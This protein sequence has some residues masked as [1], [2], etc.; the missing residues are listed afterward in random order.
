M[1]QSSAPSLSVAT[2]P[3]FLFDNNEENELYRRA[4]SAEGRTKDTKISLYL[5]PRSVFLNSRYHVGS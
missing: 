5:G 1:S 2:G 3:E 4:L